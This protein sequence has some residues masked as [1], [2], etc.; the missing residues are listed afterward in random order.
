MRC[1]VVAGLFA[2]GV[3]ACSTSVAAQRP[4]ELISADPVTE[5]P[6]GMQ[7]WRVKYWTTDGQSRAVQVLPWQPRSRCR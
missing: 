7:A 1:S 6:T 2:L 3:L 4:G 5:T